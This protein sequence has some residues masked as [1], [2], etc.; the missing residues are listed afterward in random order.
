[1]KVKNR[2]L[3]AAPVSFPIF[4]S[5]LKDSLSLAAGTTIDA[6]MIGISGRISKR[7]FF[8]IMQMRNYKLKAALVSITRLS[9]VAMEHTD[10]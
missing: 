9:A 5:L 4:G 6:S 2:K 8:S 7:T 3:K 1:M 10:L